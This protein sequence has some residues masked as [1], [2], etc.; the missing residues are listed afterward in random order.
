MVRPSAGSANSVN[1]LREV[2]WRG[3]RDLSCPMPYRMTKLASGG[4][5]ASPTRSCESRCLFQRD[6]P[7]RRV[8]ERAAI[9]RISQYRV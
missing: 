9:I 4:G 2:R 3:K 8:D 5:S 6:R 1:S 7:D